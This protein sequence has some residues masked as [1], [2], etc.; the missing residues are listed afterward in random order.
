MLWLDG[1]YYPLERD[2]SEPGTCAPIPCPRWLLWMPLLTTA[3]QVSP[4]A[5]APSMAAATPPT[6]ARSSPT[7]RSP[8]ATSSSA[9]SV[10][11]T[12]SKGQHQDIVRA[13]GAGSA[14]FVDSFFAVSGA[15]SWPPLRRG[16]PYIPAMLCRGHAFG[17]FRTRKYKTLV[18]ISIALRR[19]PPT[20]ARCVCQIKCKPGSRD[21][22]TSHRSFQCRLA[23]ECLECFRSTSW[24]AVSRPGER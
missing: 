23:R 15:P 22:A 17:C 24:Q 11:P 18:P 13:L 2:A 20:T 1:E 7:P 16:F 12:T 4:V 21:D 3:L 19:I 5:S 9:P 6:S 14:F 10:R 8:T